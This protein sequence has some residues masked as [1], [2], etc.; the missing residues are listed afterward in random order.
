MASEGELRQRQ[1]TSQTPATTLTTP[2]QQA[3]PSPEAANVHDV[4]DPRQDL[5]LM[6]IVFACFTLMTSLFQTLDQGGIYFCTRALCALISFIFLVVALGH[7]LQPIEFVTGGIDL[8]T[9]GTSGLAEI[10]AY[11][12]GTAT[13]V[14][15]LVG[16]KGA[17][18]TDVN[19]HN[20]ALSAI[21][22]VLGGF[23]VARVYSRFKDGPAD[24]P[25]ATLI[26]ASEIVGC[27]AAFGLRQGRA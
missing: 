11:Y 26:F 8:S 6:I 25:T 4:R 12:F 2:N 1:H 19:D 15:W 23:A 21:L 10:R 14:S 3:G 13:L 7:F 16:L 5:T 24:D 9:T 20:F 17:I 18:S 22:V 27:I